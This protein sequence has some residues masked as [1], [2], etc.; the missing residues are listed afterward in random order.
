MKKTYDTQGTCS[1][2]IIIDVDDATRTINSVEFVG[3]CPGNTMGV[4]RL[5]QGRPVDE[6]IALCDGIDC[7]NRGTSCPDQLARALKTL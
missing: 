4:C 6:V 1:R 2:Q 7:R 5:V 3:G